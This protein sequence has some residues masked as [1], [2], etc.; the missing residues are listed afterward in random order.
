M[1]LLTALAA[2]VIVASATVPI[3]LHGQAPMIEHHRSFTLKN[4]LKVTLVHTGV[5][6]KALVSLVLETGEIDEPAFG[7]GL[8][9]LTADMLLQGTVSRSAQ[10]IVSESA[11]L[12]THISVQ[13]GPI[14]T[15]ITGEAETVRLPRLL[16]LI[17][18]IVRHP[19]LDTA[20]FGR[21]LRGAIHVLDSTLA[22]PANLARQ[23][24]RAII[25][26]DG[27]F[28][29]PYSY[30]ATFPQLLLG[31][32]RNVYDDNYAASRTHL[33][34]SG[35][36]DDAAAENSVRDILSDWKAGTPPR[37]RAIQMATTHELV[38]VDKP[39]LERAFA[40]IG[41][42]TIDAS[43]KDYAAFEV[44]DM[45]IGG[46]DGSRVANDISSIE[47]T[48]RLGSSSIWTRKGATYWVDVLDVRAEHAGAAL[49]AVVGE[50]TALQK[51]TP[52]D[53][54]LLRARRRVV[55]S[56]QART[57]SRDGIV[58]QLE[59]ADE[60]GLADSWITDYPKRVM[61]VSA[62]EVR[63]AVRTYLDPQKMAIAIVGDRSVIEPQLEKLRPLIP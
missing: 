55:Q 60:H 11:T 38:I 12:G 62:D 28:G 30:A 17:S 27:P 34:V 16:S 15:T 10:Q 13:A 59:L 22:N 33:Y 2:T 52:S 1:K 45:I 63:A 39:G 23:Q 20:C 58:A 21:A 35:S 25:F 43:N 51:E 37:P 49:G 36:F 41:V 32:V 18:D 53:A 50:L 14:S 31:H 48:P 40:W 44:A 47:K 54:E 7:P 24:W 61:A 57:D 6:K 46:D 8:A 5:E 4:G 19:L 3:L 26:P 9:S 42:P 29:R 56:F